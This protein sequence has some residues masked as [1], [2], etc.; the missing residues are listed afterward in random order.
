MVHKVFQGLRGL[1]GWMVRQDLRAQL[2]QQALQGLRAR[3][4]TK[5]NKVN[6]ALLG[7][8]VLQGL[9]VP[10][11]PSGSRLAYLARW[12]TVESPS[13]AMSRRMA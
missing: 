3:R 11:A 5:A 6:K 1:L 8:Q 12:E 4:E 10:Q 7:Q 9:W 2:G 13:M